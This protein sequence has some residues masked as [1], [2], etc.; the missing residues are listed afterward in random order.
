MSNV[1]KELYDKGLIQPPKWLHTNTIYLTITGSTAYGAADSSVKSDMDIYGICIPPKQDVFPYQTK[2]YGFDSVNP[3]EQYQKAHIFDNDKEY[4]I[5]VY[6]IVKF[7]KL[8]LEN[9]PSCMETLFVPQEC[10]LHTT[11]VGQLIRENRKLFLHKGCWAKYKGYA[12][13]MLHKMQSK[14]PQKDSKRYA[15]REKFGF[16]V[17]FAMHVCRLLE[18]AEQILTKGDL[19]LRNN[20]EQLKAIRRGEMSVEEIISWA[21]KKEAQLEELY[22][23]SDL[24]AGPNV[25]MVRGVL[26]ECLKIHYGPLDAII[27]N[28]DLYSLTL[29]KVKEIIEKSGL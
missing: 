7:F 16:D 23:K 6:S 17:K 12:Y 3:F 1:V 2:I 10:I 8:L 22:H 26:I 24:P 9:N 19:D 25:D 14:T 4:D 11:Q 27:Q 5:N 21:S 13:S 18:Y 20:K 28:P 29:I 15:L